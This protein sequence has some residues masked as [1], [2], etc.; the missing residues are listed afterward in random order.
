MSVGLRLDGGR[1]GSFGDVGSGKGGVRCCVGEVSETG[2]D[3]RGQEMNT[4]G[5]GIGLRG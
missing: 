2:F 3:R 1:P 5:V 4:F